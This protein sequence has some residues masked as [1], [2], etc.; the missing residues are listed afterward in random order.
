MTKEDITAKRLMYDAFT[1]FSIGSRGCA[2]KSMAYLEMSLAMA[3]T[4]WSFDF[5]RPNGKEDHVG[6]GASKYFKDQKAGPTFLIKDQFASVHDGPNLLFRPR[7][8]ATD[9][10]SE[11]E[12]DKTYNSMEGILAEG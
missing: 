12:S 3:K 4:L 2:G 10:T 1:P 11:P 5:Q 6:E 9:N 8:N 7:G